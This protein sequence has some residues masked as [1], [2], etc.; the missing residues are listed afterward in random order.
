[1]R[2]QTICTLLHSPATHADGTLIV[3]VTGLI[4]WS[5]LPADGEVLREWSLVGE[6]TWPRCSREVY[7]RKVPS[8]EAA[9]SPSRISHS[10]WGIISGPHGQ[11]M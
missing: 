10:C 5:R 7:Y 2:K 3:V 4:W 1:M 6:D 8:H 9:P 11:V